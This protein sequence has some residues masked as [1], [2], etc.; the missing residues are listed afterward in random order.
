MKVS[1]LP[2]A[3]EL[4][5]VA[6]HAVDPDSQKGAAD[7]CRQFGSIRAFFG[8]DGGGDEIHLR[9]RRPHSFGINDAT[10]IRNRIGACVYANVAMK[11]VYCTIDNWRKGMEEFQNE[12]KQGRLKEKQML[13]QLIYFESVLKCI[14]TWVDESL[15]P[16]LQSA[17]NFYT[18]RL[19]NLPRGRLRSVFDTAQRMATGAFPSP[20]PDADNWLSL[21]FPVEVDNSDFYTTSYHSRGNGWSLEDQVKFA[22]DVNI[23]NSDTFKRNKYINLQLARSD[24]MNNNNKRY[25]DPVEVPLTFAGDYALQMVDCEITE[26]VLQQPPVKFTIQWQTHDRANDS[27]LKTKE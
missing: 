18:S 14:E 2:C 27:Q 8:H 5:V 20:L 11:D 10:G 4:A 17:S 12:P 19:L 6:L 24:N 21:G 16:E 26:V 1:L 9:V 3:V 7:A 15:L 22:Y 25:Y 23:V 13:S